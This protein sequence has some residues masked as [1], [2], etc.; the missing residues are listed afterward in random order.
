LLARGLHLLPESINFDFVLSN[1]DPMKNKIIY[2]TVMCVLIIYLI[3]TTYARSQDQKDVEKLG[4]TPLPDNHRCDEYY[5]QIIVFTGQRKDAGTK[6]KVHFVL[7]ENNQETTIRTFAD[8]HRS[9]F[10]RGGVNAFIMP[11]PK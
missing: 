4:V 3:L 5:Y 11:V 2:L 9:I 10:Q 8:P 7:S 1:I 6:S